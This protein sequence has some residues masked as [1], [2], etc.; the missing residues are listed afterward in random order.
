MGGRIKNLE[1]QRF[2]RLVVVSLDHVVYKKGAYWK[3]ECDCGKFKIVSARNL[4]QG[5]VQSCGCLYYK[6]H[7][8]RTEGP[9]TYVK[10]IKRNTEFIIDTEDLEKTI[11]FNWTYC[12]G[13][14]VTRS[15]NKRT[16][17]LHKYLFGSKDGFETDHKNGNTLDNRKNNLRFSTHNQNI[18]NSKR[19][20]NLVGYLGVTKVKGKKT[21]PYRAVIHAYN[22][23]H[24]IG[25]YHTAE[26]AAIAYSNKNIELHKNF[27]V[28]NRN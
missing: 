4:K 6:K 16:I 14:Y 5:Y 1:S 28:L 9:V 24:H 21:R 2:G 10:L 12:E 15:E 13:G 23:Q 17:Y 18:F 26:E 8:Y 20:S 25:Y 11:K 22:I 19:K 3:C 27:S 7:R